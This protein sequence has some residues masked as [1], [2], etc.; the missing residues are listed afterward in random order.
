MDVVKQLQRQ[1]IDFSTSLYREGFVDDQFAQL[2]KLQ[3]ESNPDFVVE[4]VS[5]FFDDSEKLVKNLAVALEQQIVDYKQVDANVHQLKE[6]VDSD[7]AVVLELINHFG[8]ADL[9]SIIFSRG[10]RFI[11]SSQN[12]SIGAKRVKDVCV[13]FRSFCEAEN[14]EGCIAEDILTQVSE[15]FAAAGATNPGSRWD[16]SRARMKRKFPLLSMNPAAL[17]TRFRSNAV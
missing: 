5:L 2:Q 9:Y 4:V 16:S 17:T 3:D 15:M 7:L 13:A 1:F 6:I 12:T 11:Y 10:I 14:H 8:G